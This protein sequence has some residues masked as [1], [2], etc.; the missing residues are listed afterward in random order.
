MHILAAQT[1]L[2]SYAPGYE[3]SSSIPVSQLSA[4]RQKNVA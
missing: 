2:K 3:T 1:T 4:A